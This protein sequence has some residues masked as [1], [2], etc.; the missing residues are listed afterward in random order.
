MTG[1]AGPMRMSKRRAMPD[2]ALGAVTRAFPRPLL[3]C[4]P[5]YLA[6]PRVGYSH[7]TKWRPME[8]VSPK[9]VTIAMPI[10]AG[11]A[12]KMPAAPL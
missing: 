5:G 2:G 10:L 6:F 3:A 9:T 11:I 1:T 4:R 7:G 8:S 12:S